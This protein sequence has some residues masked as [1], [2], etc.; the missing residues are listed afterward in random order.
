MGVFGVPLQ[1]LLLAQTTHVP[2]AW[3]PV[4]TFKQTCLVGS[5][6]AQAVAAAASHPSQVPVSRLQIGSWGVAHW[7]S[8]RQPTH[9]PFI[10][11]AVAVIT[12]TGLFGSLVAHALALESEHPW[13][14]PVD[15][16][17]MGAWGV[18]QS[19]SMR[20]PTHIPA[21][22]PASPGVQSG[23]PALRLPQAVVFAALQPRQVPASWS[24]M[25]MLPMHLALGQMN[26]VPPV[27]LA[28]AAPPTPPRPPLPPAPPLPPTPPSSTHTFLL[29]HVPIMQSL[30]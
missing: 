2:L 6:V 19:L 21:F 7:V 30:V 12:Q 25:G 27:P 24:Q 29:L 4:W 18:W 23:V 28:P 11:V 13:Q 1:S 5:F 8:I 9:I 22:E 17:Q 3:L 14:V 20:H 10:N 15:W 16:L 26:G